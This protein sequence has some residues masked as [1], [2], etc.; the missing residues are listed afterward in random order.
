ME[1]YQRPLYQFLLIRTRDAQ[2]AEEVAQDAFV[3]CWHNLERFDS[4]YRFSTFLYTI[5]Q[6]LAVSRYREA[7]RN[8]SV[9]F[10]ADLPDPRR[11]PVVELGASEEADRLWA[12]VAELLGPE[13][14]SALWLR[15]AEDLPAP[16]I[17][18]VL[19]KSPTAV[20]VMLF[21]ARRVLAHALIPPQA[22]RE[23]ARVWPALTGRLIR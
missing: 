23:I 11:E 13:T 6:R 4:R 2:R 18:G 16:V 3:R 7:E 21:R 20:R 19:G 22:E 17:A 1:I 15:Y 10:P 12:E 8:R 14:R 9:E 5:A